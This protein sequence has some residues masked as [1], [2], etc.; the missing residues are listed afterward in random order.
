MVTS[1]KRRPGIC[2]SK[3]ARRKICSFFGPELQKVGVLDLPN[4]KKLMKNARR[5]FC[6]LMVGCG[7]F[8]ILRISDD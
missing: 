1:K 8:E 4:W 6:R 5:V 3:R 2:C 7:H